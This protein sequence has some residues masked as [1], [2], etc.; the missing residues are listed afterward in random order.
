MGDTKDHVHSPGVFF[1]TTGIWN[2]DNDHLQPPS[3][4]P[5]KKTKE[6]SVRTFGSM[7]KRFGHQ[8]VLEL[9]LVK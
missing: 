7:L 1:F 4:N 5:Y 9:I 3:E 6:W 8:S 2:S